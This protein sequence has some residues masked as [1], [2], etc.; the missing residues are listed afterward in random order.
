[1]EDFVWQNKGALKRMD[2]GLAKQASVTSF[3]R[4]AE[5]AEDFCKLVR[6]AEFK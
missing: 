4:A 5:F 6:E 1:M 3:N 2:L